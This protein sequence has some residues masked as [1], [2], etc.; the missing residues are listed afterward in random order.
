MS[1]DDNDKYYANKKSVD[2]LLVS[3]CRTEFD[4]VDDL[5]LANKIWSTL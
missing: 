4:R 5:I 3:L 1:Q 2:I